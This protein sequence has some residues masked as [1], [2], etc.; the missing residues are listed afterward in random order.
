MRQLVKVLKFDEDASIAVFF[1]LQF[2]SL[3]TLLLIEHK[4]NV[5]IAAPFLAILC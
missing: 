5:S 3:T 2:G 4:A 1:F